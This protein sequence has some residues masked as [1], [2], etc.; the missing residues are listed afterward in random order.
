[1]GVL[2]QLRVERFSWESSMGE[3][4]GILYALFDAGQIG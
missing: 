4:I 1:M 2:P 3:T